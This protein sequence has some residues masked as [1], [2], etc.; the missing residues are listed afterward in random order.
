[1]RDK[2]RRAVETA[3]T[4]LIV[5]LS[6]SALWLIVGSGLF[7]RQLDTVL[8]RRGAAAPP[9][10]GTA[11]AADALPIGLAVVNE[12]GCYGVRYDQEAVA[13]LFTRFAPLL[14]EV[15]SS[16]GEPEQATAAEWERALTSAPCVYFDFEGTI[17]LRV[18]S[19]WL[20]GQENAGLTASARRLLLRGGDGA[21]A[22]FYQDGEGLCHVC[23]A[24]VADPAHLTAAVNSVEPNGAFF[25]CQSP[26][27]AVLAA[28]AL[29]TPQTPS[30]RE[31]TAAD[32]LAQDQ[33]ERLETLLDA[34]SFP[35]GITTL[36]ET[37]EGWRARSGNDMLTVVAGSTAT[38]RST[39][40]EAR[41]PVT[42]AEGESD[43]T[44][45]VNAARAL[46]MDALEPWLGGARLYLLDAREISEKSWQMEFGYA[47]GGIP[48]RVGEE[49]AATVLVDRG[50]IIQ[51][52]LHLRTYAAQEQTALILPQAQA[53]AVAAVGER[54]RPYLQLAYRD[55]GEN[56]RIGWIAGS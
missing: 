11:A 18:L 40:E 9:R 24:Q 38:Y 1:M 53:A 14:N 27:Y 12:N 32:L 7:G 16:T 20:S 46:V 28:D 41:Y 15:L 21:V 17:P 4:L 42:P 52:D 34:L 51:Y 55:G 54:E 43:L 35:A 56:V 45:A 19:A 13:A 10:A 29:I 33:Q 36:Y 8:E 25:A 39:R 22:L 50:Y 30:P 23:Q 3:K 37:P 48:V 44:A 31:Y 47:L 6:A 49:P 5:L 26:D 2:T